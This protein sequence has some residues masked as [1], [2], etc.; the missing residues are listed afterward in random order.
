M[1]SPSEFLSSQSGLRREA[2]ADSIAV[3]LIL[4]GELKRW[5]GRSEIHVELSRGS[6]VDTLAGK[7]RELCGDGFARR[8]LTQDGTFQPHIAVF[9]DGVQM[10]RL[11]GPRTQLTGGNIELMLLPVYEGG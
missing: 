8:A 2:G 9:I 5:A 11:D 4:T 6:S 7:L 10:A 1:A 3:R